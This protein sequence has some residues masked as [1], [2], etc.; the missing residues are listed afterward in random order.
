M[1][2]TIETRIID[3]PGVYEMTDVTYH[4]DPVPAGSLSSS[5]ARKLLAPSCPA[6]FRHYAD[7]GAPHKRVFDL[8][9]TAHL[10][11]L[12]AGPEIVV[13]DAKDWRT[14]AAQQERDAAYAE[15]KVPVLRAEDDAARAMAAALKADPMCAALLD[16][17]HG[18][19][20]QSLFWVDPE[21]GVWRR[22]RPD[23]LQQK[24]WQRPIV[25]DYKST[26][27]IEPRAIGRAVHNWG[28]H[29][30]EPYYLDGIEGVGIAD[31]AAFVFIFQMKTPPYLPA[32]VQLDAEA[33][34]IGRE[35]NARALEV[36]RDCQASGLWPSYAAPGAVTTISLPPYAERQ[37]LIEMAE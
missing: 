19:P 29:M 27:S 3:T 9:H 5:G 16:P 1:T 17:D 26:T 10:Y 13:V 35:R 6:L 22:V 34:L 2:A 37:H 20:E 24:P 8:G 28:Y 12:G 32:V 4:H 33:V 11:V 31:D 15:D 25:V 23:W 18:Q 36:F 21:F 14:K 30:Q 7:N